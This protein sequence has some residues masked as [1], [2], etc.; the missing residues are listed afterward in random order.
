MREIRRRWK[1]R[2]SKGVDRARGVRGGLDVDRLGRSSDVI[3]DTANGVRCVLLETSAE[4][5][6]RFEYSGVG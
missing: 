2:K 5:G 1:R 6:R 3:H 4:R